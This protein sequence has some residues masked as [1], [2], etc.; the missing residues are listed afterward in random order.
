MSRN[1]SSGLPPPGHGDRSGH[2]WSTPWALLTDI[3]EFPIDN[4]AGGL[5][6]LSGVEMQDPVTHLFQYFHCRFYQLINLIIG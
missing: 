3:D 5:K 6:H 4:C 2:K 1:N